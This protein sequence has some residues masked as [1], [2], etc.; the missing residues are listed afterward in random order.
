MKVCLL[1]FSPYQFCWILIPY[2]DI[3]LIKVSF[4]EYKLHITHEI[5]RAQENFISISNKI[6]W[7]Q[8]NRYEM[9]ITVAVNFT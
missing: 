4:Q 5:G 3:I 6:C 1:T 7:K 2:I 8:R 9:M